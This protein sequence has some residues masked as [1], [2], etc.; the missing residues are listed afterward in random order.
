MNIRIIFFWVLTLGI[1][2]TTMAQNATDEKKEFPKRIIK[3]NPFS[4]FVD[5]VNLSY[6]V[7]TKEQQSFN[8]NTIFILG[9]DLTRELGINQYE[10]TSSDT[11]SGFVLSPEYRFYFGNSEELKGTYTSPFYNLL[12]YNVSNKH[13]SNEIS[14][15]GHAIGILFGYQAMIRHR[16]ALDFNIGL[17]RR[18]QT[19]DY[20]IGSDHRSDLIYK[21]GVNIGV[22]F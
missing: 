22:A 1:F 14:V 5:V 20:K 4:V 9:L 21:I 13:A 19:I 10:L 11:Y 2:S 12:I 15:M 8:L 7:K 6:E 18:M 16:V 3:L 17:G